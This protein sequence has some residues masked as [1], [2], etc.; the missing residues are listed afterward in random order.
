MTT[1]QKTQYQE[2]G[3]LEK[4]TIKAMYKGKKER[5]LRIYEKV[6][7]MFCKGSENVR[8]IIIVAYLLPLSQLL[9]MNFSWGRSYLDL[10]PPQLKVEYC[11]QINQ[12][13]L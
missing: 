10:L 2:I 13:G 5:V 11:R 6:E 7:E 4:R 3:N 1:K 9:E 12:S 8:S